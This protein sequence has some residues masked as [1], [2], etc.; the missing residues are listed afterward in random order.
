[1]QC[2]CITCT[3][4]ISNDVVILDFS[5]IMYGCMQRLVGLMQTGDFNSLTLC[6]T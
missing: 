3:Y 5:V 6:K 1:M 4:L 2:V